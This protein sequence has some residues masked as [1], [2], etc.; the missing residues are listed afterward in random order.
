MVE[1]ALMHAER[2]ESDN[3]KPVSAK[4]PPL[5]FSRKGRRGRILV[6]DDENGPRQ[7]L[8]MLLKE[9]HDVFLASSVAN[10]LTFLETESV[11]IVITDLRMPQQTGVDL[12]REV[13]YLY[14][15]TEVIILTGYGELNTAMEAIEYGAYAYLEK[16][17]DS[18]VML[19][20]VESCLDKKRREQERRA[21]EHLAI[22]ANRMETL[23]RIV[24]G[25]MHDLGTPLSVLGTHIDL[26]KQDP[27]RHDIGKR[28]DTMTSQVQHCN[29]LVR[30]TMNFLRHSNQE[31]A[32]FSLNGAAK[33]CIE[34]AR[35]LLLSQNVALVADFD[36]ALPACEGDLVLVRQAIL[37][38]I[39]NACQ[40]MEGQI[41]PRQLR[42]ETRFENEHVC[43]AVQ[44]SGNGVPAEH[45]EHIFD[46]LFTTKGN[47]GTGLG[48]AVVQN[49]MERHGGT[50]YLE[51]SAV[52]GA[53][54]VL[55]FPEGTQAEAH[56]Q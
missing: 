51:E 10:A 17:F 36:A 6:V 3:A 55:A 8:R 25:A 15:Q 22:E 50:V 27:Q 32:P 14:P 12:L 47:K 45:R 41:E 5:G 9:E 16:P 28:L 2:N 46:A 48:L 43:L 39:Y 21:L 7:A 37:N 49:V 29:D 31:R 35:P 33:M 40:A 19:G 38:L 1:L 13:K 24:S 52:R 26:L 44:D 34:V 54:F 11:D 23:G 30:M 53:R 18:R 20:K 56:Y 4:L 42:L